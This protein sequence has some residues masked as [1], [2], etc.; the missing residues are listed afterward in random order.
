M[1]QSRGS[2]RLSTPL[3]STVQPMAKRNNHGPPLEPDTDLSP[4]TTASPS[5]GTTCPICMDELQSPCSELKM[6]QPCQLQKCGHTFCQTCLVTAF[7]NDDRHRCPICRQEGSQCQH[8]LGV[9]GRVTDKGIHTQQT[10]SAQEDYAQI[11]REIQ[12]RLVQE[13]QDGNV[14]RAAAIEEKD[15][16]LEILGHQLTVTRAQLAGARTEIRHG[17]ALAGRL[18]RTQQRRDI[19]A[20]TVQSM[21][22]L[23]LIRH[24][25]ETEVLRVD[26]V[27]CREELVRLQ[28]AL[29]HTGCDT[30]PDVHDSH[31]S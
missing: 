14:A 5:T 23:D 6:D 8:V 27:H 21:T 10:T 31:S 12:T 22:A 15:A 7:D 30:H 1:L 29:H 28:T 9:D 20:A 2:K 25:T 3:Q 11:Q 4:R 26:L 18:L 19:E 17:R 16:Q 24:Q 13:L